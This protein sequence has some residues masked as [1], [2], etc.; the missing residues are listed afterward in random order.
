MQSLRKTVFPADLEY[1][2]Q[3][4][5]T[6]FISASID[7]VVETLIIAVLLVVLVTYIFLQ[8]WRSTLVPTIAIPVSLVGTFA[9]ML[10]I[11][12]SINMTTLFGL[13]LA[14]G[15]VVDDAIVVIENVSRLMEEEHH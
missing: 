12:Y 3:Y 7:E 14:I 1:G 11:G 6:E 8:D 5:T 4:D 9:V 13:I 2:I 10:G 15:I